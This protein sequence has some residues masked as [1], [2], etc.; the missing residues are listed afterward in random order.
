M[1]WDMEQAAKDIDLDQDLG[2][3]YWS[4]RL[5]RITWALLALAIALAMGGL[6]GGG[7]LAHA[8]AGGTSKGLWVEYDRYARFQAP[9]I[10]TLH[11]ARQPARPEVARVWISYDYLG[12]GRLERISPEPVEVETESDRL[13]Y[14]FRLGEPG[15]TSQVR[16]FF[17]PERAGEITCRMGLEGEPHLGFTQFV[18]P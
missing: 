3:Q 18:F 9:T 5:Q 17:F 6:F 7:P 10:L 8:V 12:S 16:L 13:V 2:F 1:T 14:V 15:K 11:L 4:W